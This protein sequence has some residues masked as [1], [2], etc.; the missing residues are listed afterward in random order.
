MSMSA[1]HVRFPSSP[2]SSPLSSSSQ[3]SVPNASYTERFRYA[4]C[5]SLA[6]AASLCG[7]GSDDAAP[8]A[9]PIPPTTPNSEGESD[10]GTGEQH[11]DER[12][13]HPQNDEGDDV[14]EDVG[15]E[16]DGHRRAR[17]KG[18]GATIGIALLVP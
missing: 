6:A 5:C 12:G 4:T 14:G 8:E 16:G 18:L 10:S 11:G 1:A 9:L 2:D 17:S 15:E 3:S 7:G 13:E